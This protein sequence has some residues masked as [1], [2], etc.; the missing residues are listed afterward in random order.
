[1]ETALTP[2]LFLAFGAGVL[3]FVSPCCLP[4]YPAYLSYLTGISVGDLKAGTPAN[5]RLVLQ[6]GLAF[7]LGFSV[8]WVALGLVTSALAQFFLGWQGQ[9]RVIGGIFVA[10]MGLAVMGAVRIPF[11][12]REHRVQ[13]AQKPAGFFGSTLVGMTFAAGWLPCVGPILSAVL[14]LAATQP[15]Q[16]LFL[17]SAYSLGF[18]IPW[19]ALAYGL[20]S[21]RWLARYSLPL[22]RVGGALM[23]VMGF[24]LATNQLTRLAGWLVN[25]TGFQGF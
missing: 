25:L 1:M 13:L 8:I 17:L 7:V 5:R 21:A 23:V 22:E 18:A 24:L 4:V 15:G 12:M 3:S 14:A 16:G 9:L 6:H 19:L 20:G 2:N 10:A 11:L